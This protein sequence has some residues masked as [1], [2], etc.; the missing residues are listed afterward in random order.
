MQQLAPHNGRRRSKPAR[1]AKGVKGAR[2]SIADRSIR[3]QIEPLTQLFSRIAAFSPS[4]LEECAA[5]AVGIVFFF[6]PRLQARRP[7]ECLP[8]SGGYGPEAARFTANWPSALQS[9]PCAVRGESDTFLRISFLDL[10]LIPTAENDT[11]PIPRAKTSP[12]GFFLKTISAEGPLRRRSP[13][14]ILRAFLL[15]L[16]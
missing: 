14:M 6:L 1:K 2:M 10:L 15:A 7:T 13:M 12:R 11:K 8:N 16:D 5:G 9:I 3:E 4:C